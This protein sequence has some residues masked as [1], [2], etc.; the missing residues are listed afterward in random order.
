MEVVMIQ[1]TIVVLAALGI[2][3]TLT[4]ASRAED[5]SHKPKANHSAVMLPEIKI[6]GQRTFAAVDVARIEPKLASAKFYEGFTTR[7]EDAAYR[8]PF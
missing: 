3:L 8:E 4:A 5:K 7:V 2:A 6:V 1:R